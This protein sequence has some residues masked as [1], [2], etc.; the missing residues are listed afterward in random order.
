MT[1]YKYLPSLNVKSYSDYFLNTFIPKNEFNEKKGTSLYVQYFRKEFYTDP[2]IMYLESELYK[3]YNF[4]PIDYFSIF[5]HESPQ[6]IHHDGIK[7]PRYVSLNLP[8]SGFEST[9]MIFYK[10]IGNIFPTVED[11][12]YYLPETVEPV[13]ELEGSNEWV[14]VNSSIPHNITNVDFNNPRF[15]LCL[16]F[17]SNPTIDQLLSNINGSV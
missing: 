3:K 9:K 11:A 2:M 8:L 6:P 7:I 12:N 16:R 4:P 15:T 10:I 17:A 13:V 1:Y 5:K 14:L